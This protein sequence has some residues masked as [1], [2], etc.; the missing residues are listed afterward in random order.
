MKI[1]CTQSCKSNTLKEF[2]ALE[3][4]PIKVQ[5]FSEQTD[6]ILLVKTEGSMDTGKHSMK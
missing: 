6:S 2:V 4:V 1:A 3:D 5:K